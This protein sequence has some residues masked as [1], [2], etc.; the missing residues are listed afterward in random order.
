MSNNTT[1]NVGTG[2]DVITDYQRADGSK[3][4]VVLL[5]AG[6]QGVSGS[7]SPVTPSNPLPTQDTTLLNAQSTDGPVAQ[8]IAPDPNSDFAGTDFFSALFDYQG[9]GLNLSAQNVDL[10]KDPSGAQ[11]LSDAP[12]PTV[13]TFG[14]AGEVNRDMLRIDTTGYQSVSVQISGTWVGTITFYAS[15]DG[16]NATAISAYQIGSAGTVTTTTANGVFVF[17]ALA[18]WLIIRPTAYTSGRAF[19]MAYLRNSAVTNLISGNPANINVNQTVNQVTGPQTVFSGFTA[20][21][22]SLS[23]Q[24]LG[25]MPVLWSDQQDGS[26]AINILTD[27]LRE[28]KILNTQIYNLQINLNSGVVS[29]GQVTATF[30]QQQPDDPSTLRADPTYVDSL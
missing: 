16:Q 3:T 6:I 13:G 14:A 30:S 8:F 7:P 21:G 19:G 20:A 4:Q 28:L 1:L 10:K 9:T 25:A 15:N 23:S 29:Y 27:V 2:G 5:D 18:R 22:S 11:F 12:S 24:N 17:P 26:T